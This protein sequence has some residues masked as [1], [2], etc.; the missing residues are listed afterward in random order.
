LR[1]PLPVA[2]RHDQETIKIQQKGEDNRQRSS[3]ARKAEELVRSVNKL[4][5][6][7]S[8]SP[9]NGPVMWTIAYAL[10]EKPNGSS[11]RLTEL[12]EK[13]ATYLGSS[14]NSY[15]ARIAQESIFRRISSGAEIPAIELDFSGRGEAGPFSMNSNLSRSPGLYRLEDSW[16]CD[17]SEFAKTNGEIPIALPLAVHLSILARNISDE[18]SETT[19]PAVVVMG[20]RRGWLYLRPESL[21]APNARGKACIQIYDDGSLAVR[22]IVGLQEIIPNFSDLGQQ[23]AA[24]LRALG[25]LLGMRILEDSSEFPLPGVVRKWI[26]ARGSSVTSFD[27]QFLDLALSAQRQLEEV[28][29]VLE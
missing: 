29:N 4:T 21:L 1:N 18:W 25:A 16:I 26:K 12:V 13:V 24:M 15:V 22:D 14:G 20:E 28:A 3:K 6:F 9:E 23:P 5:M 2:A 11:M 27:Q 17:V 8:G 19:I 10:L 7:D